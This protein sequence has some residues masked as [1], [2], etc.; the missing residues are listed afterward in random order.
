MEFPVEMI[1]TTIACPH[2]GQPTEL[3]LAAPATD[4]GLPARVWIWT[5]VAA[6]ILV[7]GLLGALVALK[8]AQAWAARQK[9]SA[10]HKTANGEASGPATNSTAVDGPFAKI[11]FQVSDITFEQTAG[12][13]LIYAVGIL[14]NTS[15]RQRFGVKLE[16]DLLDAAGQPVGTAK[17]YQTLIEPGGTWQFKALVM[18]P[19]AV[20]ARL[21][22]I[23]EDQ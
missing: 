18:E 13:S 11:G 2:C 5:G 17:D 9:S 4:S 19:K 20:S 15:P 6:V 8:R 3:L 1:G 16:F 10:A 14:T 21:A 22:A 7:L 23:K 12:S